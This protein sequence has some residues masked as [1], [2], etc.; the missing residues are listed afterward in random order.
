M[1]ELNKN[2]A[3]IAIVDDDAPVCEALESLLKLI[4][5]RTA[6]LHLCPQSP[7][8]PSMSERV[9]RDPRCLDA[10]DE[11]PRVATSSACL[12]PHPNHLHHGP[13]PKGTR[14]GLAFGSD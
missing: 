4:A 12:P 8:L 6:R 5:F 10:G 14:A 9:L 11:R 7:G 13:G 3:L 2:N 1:K